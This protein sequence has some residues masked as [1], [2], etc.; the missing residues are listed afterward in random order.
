M[1]SKISDLVDNLSG[2][3]NKECK[4]CME[5]K[6]IKSECD[7]IGFRNNILNYKCKECGKRC[8][9]SINETSINFLIMHQFGSGDLNKFVLLLRKGVSLMNTWIVGKNLMKL[10]Y[11][12]MKLIIMS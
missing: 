7:F 4:S 9:K 11:S 12:L 10:Q 2:I 1:E 8:S 6:K 3:N 5:R